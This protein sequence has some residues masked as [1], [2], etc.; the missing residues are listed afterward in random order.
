MKARETFQRPGQDHSEVAQFNVFKIEEYKQTVLIPVNRKNVYKITLL[1]E[2]QGTLIYSNKVIPI[3]NIAMVFTNP[4]IPFSYESLT[5]GENGYFCFF[6]EEFINEQLKT[7]SLSRSP[8]FAVSGNPVLFPNE[9]SLS[10]IR[11]IF[12]LMLMENASSYINKHE[13]LR[14]FVQIL[15]HESLKIDPPLNYVKTVASAE[16]LTAHFLE[17]L[18]RQFPISS[19]HHILQLKN[20]NEFADQLSVHANH[21]NRV[22]KKTTGFTTSEHISQRIVKEAETLLLQSNWDVAEIGYCLGYDHAPN[23]HNFFKRQTGKTANDFRKQY[24]A[25]S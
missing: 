23:F 6:T 25:N 7:N 24:V 2:G 11:N 18:E 1:L 22:L 19:P 10:V 17:L 4:M 14:N 3:K 21:L 20:A 12:E 15:I 16:R 9:A 13:L 8:L 5:G